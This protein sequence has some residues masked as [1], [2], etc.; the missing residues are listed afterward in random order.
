M[1]AILWFYDSS[2]RKN[3]IRDTVLPF[4]LLLKPFK[5]YRN[6]REFVLKLYLYFLKYFQNY[7]FICNLVFL[8]NI[9]KKREN[10]YKLK[11]AIFETTKRQ[12][13]TN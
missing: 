12:L 13:P 4:I 1:S 8:V 6:K 10:K 2:L 7:I 5:I 3:E 9:R 11:S